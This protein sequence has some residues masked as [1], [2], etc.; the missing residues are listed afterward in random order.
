MKTLDLKTS[1][2][3]DGSKPVKLM[4]IVKGLL[5][6]PQGPV[7]KKSKQLTTK[8]TDSFKSSEEVGKGKGNGNGFEEG[9]GSG[10]VDNNDNGSGDIDGN[11]IECDNTG[12]T[13]NTKELIKAID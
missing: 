1:L 7:G 5:A 3:M 8:I 6:K 2:V 9:N 4:N 13:A 11:V 12:S 10:K